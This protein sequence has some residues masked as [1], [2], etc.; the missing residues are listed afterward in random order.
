MYML[1]YWLRNATCHMTSQISFGTKL[2]NHSCITKTVIDVFAI[3][4]V[5]LVIQWMV[6]S[7]AT[8]S[9]PNSFFFLQTFISKIWRFYF[10]SRSVMV[11]NWIGLTTGSPGLSCRYVVLVTSGGTTAI[12]L[13]CLGSWPSWIAFV[14]KPFGWLRNPDILLCL[15]ICIETDSVRTQQVERAKFF[16]LM[17]GAARASSCTAKCKLK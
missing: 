7:N 10:I 12:W 17:K 8:I 13:H 4:S 16:L 1:M 2:Q 5:L 9:T 15:A 11:K 3:S 14:A 6:K